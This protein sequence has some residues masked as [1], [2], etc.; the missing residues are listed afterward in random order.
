MR[1]LAEVISIE[2]PDEYE[3]ESWQ[4]NDNERMNTIKEYRELGNEFYRNGK[5]DEAEEKYK[6]ALGII[7]QLLI[8]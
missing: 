6:V 7:E 5:I 3:K 8:K 2:Q 4:L 1:K